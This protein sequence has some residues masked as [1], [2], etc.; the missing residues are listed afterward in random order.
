VGEHQL[1]PRFVGR[2]ALFREVGHGSLATVHLG[3][4]LGAGARVVAVKRVAA[5]LADDLLRIS[6]LLGNARV[7]Q[8]NLAA[9]VESFDSEGALYIVTEY[10]AGESFGSLMKL[11][12]RQRVPLPRSILCGIVVGVLR[13]LET[14]YDGKTGEPVHADVSPRNVLIGLDGVPVV[15]DFGIAGALSRETDVRVNAARLAYLAPEQ[16]SGG[17]IDRRTDVYAAG[18][19]L[20]EGLAGRRLFDPRKLEGADAIAKEI[21]AGSI[22]PPSKFVPSTPK[23]L[24]EVVMRSL[25]RSREDRYPTASAMAI[26]IEAMIEIAPGKS[27]GEWVGRVASA[28]LDEKAAVVREVEA[29]EL[30]PAP[31]KPPP[32]EEKAAQPAEPAA[33][34]PRP[35]APRVVAPPVRPRPPP[36]SAVAAALP[37]RGAPPPPSVQLP[38]LPPVTPTVTKAI[39]TQT[40][41]PTNSATATPIQTATPTKTA[42]ATPAQT[43]TPTKTATAAATPTPTATSTETAP[44]TPASATVPA[45]PVVAPPI[46]VPSPTRSVPRV[47]PARVTATNERALPS[48][49]VEAAP[50]ARRQLATIPGV[51]AASPPAATANDPPP[52]DFSKWNSALP[53]LESA[54]EPPVRRRGLVWVSLVVCIVLGIGVFLGLESRS[55]ARSDHSTSDPAPAKT[56]SIAP[57][58]SAPVSPQAAAVPG[59]TPSSAAS[60]PDTARARPPASS[61]PS[62]VSPATQPSEATPTRKTPRAKPKYSYDPTKI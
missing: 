30:P 2:Y 18:V 1:E 54:E 28:V 15:V 17:A 61:A 7:Q 24:D 33:P 47:P 52:P 50:P 45:V 60:D 43:A 23:A 42:T 26:A 53:E 19:M 10:V 36:A 21:L 31:P 55:P 51:G 11:A 37:K 40:A 62:P 8:P 25:A 59:E 34:D 39:A 57:P 35:E 56:P 5:N 20:W 44:A 13:G 29:L 12:G 22:E 46:P 27:I 41:T 6:R 9:V 32:A 48:V 14:A 3:R 49:I 58:H 16:L 4:R 38:R